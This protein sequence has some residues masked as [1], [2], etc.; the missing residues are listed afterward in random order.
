MSL[1]AW[2]VVLISQLALVAGQIFLKRAMGR[3]ELGDARARGW[4]GQLVIGIATM[5]VWFLLWL[6]L[7]ARVDLSQLMP[8]EGISPLLIVIGAM[9]FLGEKLTWRGWTGVALTCVGVVLVSAS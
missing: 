6:G 1:T 9:I 5:T 2:I 8:L 7:M 3:R 4:V